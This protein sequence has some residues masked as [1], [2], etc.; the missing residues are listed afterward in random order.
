M[1]AGPTEA[2]AD[3]EFVRVCQLDDLS[4]GRPALA[5]IHE[6]RV[7]VVRTGEREVHAV[8]DTCTHGQVSLSE[9]EVDGYTLECWL[10]GSRF[11]LCTGEPTGPPATQPVAVYPVRIE[12]EDVL[13]A[14]TPQN[15]S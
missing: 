3:T 14:L 5:V 12:G 10:H 2:A 15:E 8:N 7:A 13:I 6:V 9:G 4:V 11:N 1:S